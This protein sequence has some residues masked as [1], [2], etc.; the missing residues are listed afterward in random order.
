MREGENTLMQALLAI[1][2][3]KNNNVGG[4]VGQPTNY[5]DAMTGMSGGIPR[6]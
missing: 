3:G 6:N 5:V 2:S 4:S 1:M